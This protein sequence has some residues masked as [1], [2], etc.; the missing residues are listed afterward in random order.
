[1]FIHLQTELETLPAGPR[2]TELEAGERELLKKHWDAWAGDA[3]AAPGQLKFVRGFIEEWTC[4]AADFLAVGAKV[5][6]AAPVRKVSLY[7]AYRVAEVA[8][9]PALA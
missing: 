6:S 4:T 3:R 2:R 7:P 8:A 9:H 1:M 5:T